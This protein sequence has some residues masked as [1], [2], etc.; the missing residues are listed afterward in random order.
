MQRLGGFPSPSASEQR[1]FCLPESDH[2][3]TY[4]LALTAAHT[5]Q[6]SSVVER[7]AV[8]R[9]VV[10]SNPTAGALLIGGEWFYNRALSDWLNLGTRLGRLF[11]PTCG[12]GVALSCKASARPL[13][14]PAAVLGRL[15]CGHNCYGKMADSLKT[16]KNNENYIAIRAL[17][18]VISPANEKIRAAARWVATRLRVVVDG[19]VAG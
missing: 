14:R 17:K 12:L 16:N 13:S 15:Y 11:H 1:G 7:S 6:R 8:N 3:A 18:L 4:P 2:W 9:L 10:G 19:T 5:I